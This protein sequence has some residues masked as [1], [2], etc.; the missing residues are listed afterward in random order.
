MFERYEGHLLAT[1]AG[2]EMVSRAEKIEFEIQAAGDSI[3]GTDGKV[4]GNVRITSVA[5]IINRVLAPLLPEFLAL[6]RNL[7]VE[8]NA[9]TADLSL[10]RREADIAL[11]LT[12]PRKEM[13]ALAKRIATIGY[14]V[15]ASRHVAPESVAWI[16]YS[17]SMRFLPQSN[18]ISEIIG[19]DETKLSQVRVN[20]AETLLQVIKAGVGKS[21][22]PISLCERDPELVRIDDASSAW[23]RELWMMVHPE[24]RKLARVHATMK[25]LAGNFG[26]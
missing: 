23:Q 5:W 13:R 8:M 22:L 20:D 12:R 19:R 1:E 11:R 21:F 9:D 15:F 10:M 14:G 24:Q 18:W 26:E 25:W 17:E 2:V 7:H 4:A 6:H 16:M 3:A